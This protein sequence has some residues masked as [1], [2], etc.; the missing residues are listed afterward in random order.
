MFASF[1]TLLRTYNEFVTGRL[2][3]Y[4][5]SP[6]EVTVLDALQNVGTASAIAK[7]ADVSKA[8]VSRSVKSLRDKGLI[9]ITISP[10]DKREQDLRLT[11]AG[12][13]AA[14]RISAANDE[15]FALATKNT[16]D[17]AL[18]ITELMLEIILK[19]LHEGGSGR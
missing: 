10:I 5:L 3:E 8:L 4:S 7:D 11:D 14:E 6:N 18:E 13:E 2:C 15:F 19:N 16:D 12:R 1:R 9:E 17:K